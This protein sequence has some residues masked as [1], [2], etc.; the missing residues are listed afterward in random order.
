[1]SIYKQYLQTERDETVFLG[2]PA[3]VPQKFEDT[4]R[5]CMNRIPNV[6]EAYLLLMVR[7]G[8]GGYLLVIDSEKELEPYISF[9]SDA[10]VPFLHKKWIDIISKNTKFG[11]CATNGK[12]P[13]YKA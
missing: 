5:K 11:F 1:M 10:C 6:R 7:D 3:E 8:K 4:L 9:I 2:T 12:I 13:F